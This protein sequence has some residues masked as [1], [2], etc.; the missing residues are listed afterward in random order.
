MNGRVVGRA[1]KPLEDA[2]RGT[3]V[4]ARSATVVPES[5]RRSVELAPL[6]RLAMLRM[7]KTG[8]PPDAGPRETS[9]AA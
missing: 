6:V 9:S 5:V 2:A 1:A 4:P 7:T 3:M 8:V